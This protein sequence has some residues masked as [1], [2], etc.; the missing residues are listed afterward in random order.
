MVDLRNTLA[1]NLRQLRGD[2]T[3]AAFARKAGITQASINRIEQG[4]QNVTVSTLQ[5]LCDRLK[6]KPSDLLD[7]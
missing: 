7:K 1:K 3:Q 2:M 5:T 6:C 4:T